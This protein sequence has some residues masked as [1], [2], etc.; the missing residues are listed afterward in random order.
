MPLPGPVNAGL[1]P[2]RTYGMHRATVDDDDDD[3]SSDPGPAEGAN[4]R[5][6]PFTGRSSAEDDLSHGYQ[7]RLQ[8]RLRIKPARTSTASSADNPRGRFSAA[9]PS[10]GHSTTQYRDAGGQAVPYR[11]YHSSLANGSMPST[12]GEPYDPALAY[13]ESMYRAPAYGQGL[14]TRTDPPI[15]N[16]PMRPY[17]SQPVH[18]PYMA[19]H[20]TPP[21]LHSHP[22]SANPGH[23][24]ERIARQLR[25][26][27]KE[28][29]DDLH[30]KNE[31]LRQQYEEEE[32]IQRD[33]ERI[34]K[35]RRAKLERDK[36]AKAKD[37]EAMQ[38]EIERRIKEAFVM[39][40]EEKSTPIYGRNSLNTPV[41]HPS[42]AS[43]IVGI[44]DNIGTM[45]LDG[46]SRFGGHTSGLERVL[47]SL[48]DTLQRQNN[49]PSRSGYLDDFMHSTRQLEERGRPMYDERFLRD[50]AER[51]TQQQYSIK[52]LEEQLLQERLSKTTQPPALRAPSAGPSRFRRANTDPELES[53]VSSTHRSTPA[54]RQ[55]TTPSE[56]NFERPPFTTPRS[57]AEPSSPGVG[58]WSSDTLGQGPPPGDGQRGGR[59]GE[60][61]IDYLSRATRYPKDSKS[62]TPGNH[63][64]PPHFDRLPQRVS[65]AQSMES[66]SDYEIELSGNEGAQRQS[67]PR[68][69]GN[70]KRYPEIGTTTAGQPL[71]QSP[72]YTERPL[73]TR[74]PPTASAHYHD[75][76]SD[77]T[78]LRGRGRDTVAAAGAWIEGHLQDEEL[79][80]GSSED[81]YGGR[82]RAPY[83]L[84]PESRVVGRDQAAIRVKR[85]KPRAPTPPPRRD[86]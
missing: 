24:S 75:R 36:K 62:R 81:L 61:P 2:G 74:R 7:N 42:L 72:Q 27:K 56:Y 49:H 3:W 51:V 10:T 52:D 82:T 11:G 43:S 73:G 54:G 17:H 30:A 28:M 25:R 45:S 59:I 71:R 68:L 50:L 1:P 79:S 5:T 23:E 69:R 63:V 38:Q 4:H 31:I 14:Y 16:V 78:G 53:R 80:A 55:R 19:Q 8:R 67:H 84:V 18:G 47:I 64:N 29:Y 20:V 22:P 70:L 76:R 13:P 48:V 21:S 37:Q 65:D 15:H 6:A 34:R 39:A 33:Q 83:A 57:P 77:H 66:L 40:R 85:E 58:T 46:V 12:P 86:A 44:N 41:Y 26:F 32:Q 9:G 35:Q 60:D